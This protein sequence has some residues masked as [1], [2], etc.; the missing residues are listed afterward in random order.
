M[1]LTSAS[2]LAGLL[3]VCLAAATQ[4]QTREGRLEIGGSVGYAGSHSLGTLSAT[5]TGNG[6]PSGSPM[7]L[8]TTS[9]SLEGGPLFEGRVGWHLTRA[10][11]VEGTF[12]VIPTHLRTSITS[13]F[14]QA[15]NTVSTSRLTQYTAEVGAVW[16]LDALRFAQRRVRP[17]VTGGGGYLRQLHDSGTLVQTG[18]SAYAGGG[19]TIALREA[20]RGKRST[21]KSVGLRG[22]VRVHFTHGGF[23]AGENAWRASPT[24]AGGAYVCF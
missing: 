14:E 1:R 17:F 11:A 16:H 20:L 24:L 10:L 13:D 18:R 8:F 15:A 12:G 5:E 22:D 19:V 6:V 23:E 3:C 2:L 7:T 21:L 4:A 9:S